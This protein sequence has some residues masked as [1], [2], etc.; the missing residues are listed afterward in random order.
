M[1]SRY[2]VLTPE[3]IALLDKQDPTSAKD[4]GFQKMMVDF[5]RRFRRGTQELKVSDD[6]I[7][8]IASYAF[9]YKNGG[10][11]SRLLGIFGRSLGPTLGRE[12]QAAE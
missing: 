4:G 2:L 6:D 5:Q 8:R 3:E 10:W 7:E 1:A 12:E 9:D 11:Q